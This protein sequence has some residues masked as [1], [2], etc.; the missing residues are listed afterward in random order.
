MADNTSG[1]DK[2]RQSGRASEEKKHIP[3][4]LPSPP[5]CGSQSVDY[6]KLRFKR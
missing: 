3:L 2:S 1:K 4:G 5:F 6:M